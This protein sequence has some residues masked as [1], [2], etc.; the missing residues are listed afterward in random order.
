MGAGHRET[1]SSWGEIDEPATLYR[2]HGRKPGPALEQP[3]SVIFI[4]EG[5]HVLNRQLLV[6][7]CGFLVDEGP[8]RQRPGE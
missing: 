6:D 8:F 1:A 5:A 2:A 7:E 4:N 3:F